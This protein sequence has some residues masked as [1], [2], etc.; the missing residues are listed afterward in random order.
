MPSSVSLSAGSSPLIVL[1]TG[2]RSA[3]ELGTQE[4]RQSKHLRFSL[5][6]WHVQP[7]LDWGIPKQ[8]MGKGHWNSVS[9]GR[10]SSTSMAG[11]EDSK[12]G[13]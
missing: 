7:H 13:G 8:L 11:S 9:E 10:D 2:N 12:D 1:G 6:A 4:T 3:S 5:E